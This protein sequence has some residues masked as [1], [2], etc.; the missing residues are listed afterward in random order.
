[1]LA[2]LAA[3]RGIRTVVEPV[4]GLTI[5]EVCTALAAV[6][7]V[8]RPEFQ[9]LRPCVEAARRILSAAQ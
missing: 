3:A 2:D 1:M 8:G 6:R 7:H 5:D 9:L 4:P